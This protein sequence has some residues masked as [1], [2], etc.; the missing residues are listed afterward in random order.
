MHTKFVNKPE[1]KRPCGIP[2]CRWEDNIT[3]DLNEIGFESVDWI[4][5]TQDR[6]Q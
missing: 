1:G 3:M 4:H 6:D 2:G 5:L